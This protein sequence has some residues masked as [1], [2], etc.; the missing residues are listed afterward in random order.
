[1]S[2]ELY[3][4]RVLLVEDDVNAVEL[5]SEIL[6][7]VG[8]EVATAP[9]GREGLTKIDEF[10]PEVILLDLQMPG[11]DGYELAK[12]IRVNPKQMMIPI[13][14]IS[15]LSDPG[16]RARAIQCGADDF[17]AKPLKSEDLILRVASAGR[18]LRMRN[19]IAR[20]KQQVVNLKNQQ[21]ALELEH[22]KN[23]GAG[24][25]EDLDAY[26]EQATSQ[27]RE[28]ILKWAGEGEGERE[29]ETGTVQNRLLESPMNSMMSRFNSPA[30]FAKMGAETTGISG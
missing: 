6:T 22:E 28:S 10:R 9:D 24:P 11:R 5:L 3:T 18:L 19:E 12:L 1:M 23:R 8:N 26:I 13:I 29:G 27:L 20:L 4:A 14:M 17:M 2:D 7:S 16:V 25:V 15:G 30:T 21:A